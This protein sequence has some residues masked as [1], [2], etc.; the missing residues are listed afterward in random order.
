MKLFF[1]L[2]LICITSF[3]SFCETQTSYGEKKNCQATKKTI[4]A[5]INVAPPVLPSVLIFE[6]Y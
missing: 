2:S 3:S 5:T 6:I 1:I 4:G